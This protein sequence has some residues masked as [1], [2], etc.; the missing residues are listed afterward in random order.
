MRKLPRM[1]KIIDPESREAVRDRLEALRRYH[2]I[3]T[4]AEFATRAGIAPQTYSGWMSCTRDVSRDAARK[5][6]ETYGVSRDFIY[7]GN[8]AALPH[9]M[10]KD[11]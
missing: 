7:T 8:K 6:S 11:L 2:R 5:L 9:I 3:K 1:N 10:A 4:Q